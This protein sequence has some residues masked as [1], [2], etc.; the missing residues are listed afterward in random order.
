MR[1]VLAWIALG[2]VLSGA[3]GPTRFSLKRAP[4]GSWT[5]LTPQGEPFFALGVNHLSAL[6][7][8]DDGEPDVFKSKYGKDWSLAARVISERL[9]SWNFNTVGPGTPLKLRERWPTFARIQTHHAQQFLRPRDFEHRDVFDPAFRADVRRKISEAVASHR[10]TG[11]LIGILWGDLTQW[12]PELERREKGTDWLTYFRGL[13]GRTPGKRAYVDFL[14]ERHGD[15]ASIEKAYGIPVPSIEWLYSSVF[16]G[17]DLGR[18]AVRAD[19][20]EFLRHIAREFYRHVGEG[21]RSAAPGV[22]QF[23]EVYWA[24][25]VP[26]EILDEAL[27]YLDAVA[28]QYGPERSPYAG[29]GYERAFDE[30]FFEAL[31]RR[32]GKPILIADHAI[33]FPTATFP[34]TLWH[35]AESQ[36][37][38]GRLYRDFVTAAAS[39]PWVLGYM[40]CQ[41]ISR[42]SSWRSLLKQGLVDV[43]DTPFEPLVSQVAAANAE[44]LLIFSRRMTGLVSRDR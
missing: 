29:P 44:A 13:A 8:A 5:L 10:E 16:L 41:Y 12:D 2:P 40:R 39:K 31:H 20:R 1:C 11:T 30:K 37:E 6:A 32:T 22:L 35:Q 42:Y 34:S 24:S 4:N 15:I 23:G 26:D 3:T 17:L 38:A 18:E 19:D 7:R 14:I 28:V 36:E 43:D 27:P 9:A 21:F 25:D 33:T